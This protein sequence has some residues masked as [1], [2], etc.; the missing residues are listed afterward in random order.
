MLAKEI[1]KDLAGHQNVTP[2]KPI[3]ETMYVNTGFQCSDASLFSKKH[4]NEEFEGR[5]PGLIFTSTWWNHVA[6]V[7][8]VLAL[9]RHTWC[10]TQTLL[11]F[12]NTLVREKQTQSLLIKVNI[13]LLLPPHPLLI[14]FYNRFLP[15]VFNRKS[16]LNC[17]YGKDWNKLGLREEVQKCFPCIKY[18]QMWQD[19]NSKKWHQ[20]RSFEVNCMHQSS[21]AA[22]YR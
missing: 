6:F 22:N 11:C 3:L 9:E 21:D 10:W 13:Q 15:N 5:F 12:N 17:Y 18:C 7:L 16:T 2:S 1:D 14:W 19:S 8:S 20:A 4:M